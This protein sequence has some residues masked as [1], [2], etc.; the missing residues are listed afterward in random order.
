MESTRQL[1]VA[2]LVQKEMAEI[3]QRECSGMFN[4]ALISVTT[5]RISPDLSFAKVYLSI[6]GTDDKE[7]TIEMIKDH[8]N[9]LRRKLGS[10]VG[11]QLRIVPDIAFYL[12]DSVDYAQ[13]INE[14]L[15][16]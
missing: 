15:N 7:G 14:L 13:K 3:F 8:H 1:K 4:R 9:E 6:F 12:D 16:K 2:R 11:K 5:V 10:R